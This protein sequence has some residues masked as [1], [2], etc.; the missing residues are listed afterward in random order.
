MAGRIVEKVSSEELGDERKTVHGY[1]GT[2]LNVL[3]V[4]SNGAALIK[5]LI[6]GTIDIEIGQVAVADTPEFWEDTS[7][8]VGDSP[9]TIDINAALGRNAT[10]GFVAN[11]G[12]GNFTI[13]F[14]NDGAA[15]GDAITLK[16]D[17]SYT[18]DNLSVDS[19]KITHVADSSYRVSA[20]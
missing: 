5:G 4:D 18:F 19:I 8:V 16:K 14:S 1:D 20:V 3:N 12:D 13:A 10:K 15:F 17:E 9:F 7:F 6:D 11:D 2:D